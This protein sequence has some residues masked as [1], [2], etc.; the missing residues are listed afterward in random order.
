MIITSINGE[1]NTTIKYNFIMINMYYLQTEKYV[2]TIV[3]VIII[4]II[5]IIIIVVVVVV[6]FVIA[7]IRE[8]SGPNRLK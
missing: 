4:I 1:L 5:I 8:K 6:V 7:N 3:V 2:L